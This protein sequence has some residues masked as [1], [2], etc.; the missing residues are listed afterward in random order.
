DAA[1]GRHQP[2]AD[3]AKTVAVK[4]Y[5]DIRLGGDGLNAHDVGAA[6]G[7][8]REHDH[9]RR[10]RRRGVGDVETH[11]DQHGQ[12]PASTLAPVLVPAPAETTLMLTSMPTKASAEPRYVPCSGIAWEGSRAT[13]TRTRSRVPT[14]PLVGSN[15]IQPALGR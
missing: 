15:S 9:H 1:G 5:F 4:S 6:R 10:R 2:A 12:T 13:A 14:M 11:L 8:D 3:I 7:M